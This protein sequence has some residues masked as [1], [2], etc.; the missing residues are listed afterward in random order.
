MANTVLQDRNGPDW[1]LGFINV[2]TPGTPVNIMSLVDATNVNDPAT[3]TP[4]TA[5]AN[6]YTP[7]AYQ[8]NFTGVRL[9]ASHGLRDNQANAYVVRFA[10]K[11][12]GSGNYDDPGVIVAVIK[13]GQT[14]V[15]TAA[16]LNRNVFS[17]YRY[18]IDADTASDG[19]LV[20]MLIQ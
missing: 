10:A 12:A 3:A 15:L 17:P 2:V 7:R 5:G 4:G 19:A 6:E 13:P 9:G 8:I 11:G 14:F 16:A 1:P 18:Y 20:T